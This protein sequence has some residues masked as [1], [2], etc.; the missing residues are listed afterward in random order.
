MKRRDK[1]IAITSGSIGGLLML[2]LIVNGLVLSPLKRIEEQKRITQEKLDEYTVQKR[3]QDNARKRLMEVANRRVG[4]DELRV[5]ETIRVRLDQLLHQCGLG[6]DRL[7]L[8][9]MTGQRVSGAYREVG[10]VVRARGSLEQITDFFYLLSQQPF[11]LRVDDV[12]MQPVA[13]STD[14]DL[15]AKCST[16]VLDLAKNEKLAEVELGTGGLDIPLE[17]QER[18]RF[19]V[20]TQR[21]L[22]RPYIPRPAEPAPPQVVRA[23]EPPPAP[24]A[25]APPAP[26][27]E[28]AMSRFKVVG[29]PTWNGEAEVLVRDLETGTTRSYR[30]GESLAGGTIAHVD[31]RPMPNPDN[32]ALM[33]YSRVIVRVDSDYYA[34]D[35]GRTLAQRRRLKQDELPESLQAVSVPVEDKTSTVAAEVPES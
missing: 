6:N 19:A 25:P 35:L 32:A 26:E 8:K 14:L 21:D 20:I 13:R 16:I 5:S 9:P 30:C 29:L 17:S 28:L 31:Y 12:S 23:P 18:Q 4:D 11:L 2:L 24:P 22:F 3:Q 10:W 34:I 15:E 27:P 1:I 33:V 7:S